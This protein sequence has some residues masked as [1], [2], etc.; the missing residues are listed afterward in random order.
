MYAEDDDVDR[1][2]FHHKQLHMEECQCGGKDD[3][4]LDVPH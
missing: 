1:D 2:A 3:A 4:A